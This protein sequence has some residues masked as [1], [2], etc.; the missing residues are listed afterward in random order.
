MNNF[1]CNGICPFSQFSWLWYW[2]SIVVVFMVGWLWYGK[3]FN[4]KWIKAVR[5][6]C[7]C[8]A[9]LSKGEKCTCKN[10]SM[11]PL[12]MYMFMQLVVT[13]LLGLMYFGL[14]QISIWWSL[15]VAVA[16]AGWMKASL[17]FQIAEWKRYVTLAIIDVGYFF[18]ASLLFMLFASI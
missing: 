15:I 6:Q 13:M 9:D 4:K 14:T 1:L 8:G 12:L 11:L 16:I 3:L 5:Y 2:I 18:L 10:K 7:T 17:K